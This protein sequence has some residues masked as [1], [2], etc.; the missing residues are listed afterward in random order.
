MV[1]SEPGEP[2]GTG[3]IS[4]ERHE[5]GP[6]RLEKITWVSMSTKTGAIEH[7]RA[8]C[9]NRGGHVFGTGRAVETAVFSL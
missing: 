5:Q 4:V 9:Q 1:P 8:S 2:G 6:R 3:M 7:G